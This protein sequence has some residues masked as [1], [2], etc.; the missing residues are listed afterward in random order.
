MMFFKALH[1][2]RRRLVQA[3]EFQ[4]LKRK[5]MQA[6]RFFSLQILNSNVG[7]SDALIKGAQA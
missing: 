3:F 4:Y 2:A 7:S 5:E 1:N 6:P